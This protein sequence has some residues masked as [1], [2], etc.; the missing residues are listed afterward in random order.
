MSPLYAKVDFSFSMGI[1]VDPDNVLNNSSSV[2]EIGGLY[3]WDDVGNLG[4]NFRYN[5]T[6]IKNKGISETNNV[7]IT[8]SD[9]LLIYSLTIFDFYSIKVDP[10]FGMG[11][12]LKERDSYFADL[13]AAGDQKISGS[14]EK[15]ALLSFGLIISKNVVK[16]LSVF[17]KPGISMYDFKNSSN[18]YFVTGGIS[19]SI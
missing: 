19:V 7:G 16:K 1:E 2:F 5:E 9:F 18:N 3:N 4:I 17:I 13:G 8:I 6:A 11:L 12:R 14:S 10:Y 15:Y